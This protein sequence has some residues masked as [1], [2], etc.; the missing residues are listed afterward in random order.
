MTARV[1]VLTPPG[2]GAVATVAVAGPG[3]WD[4]IRSLFKPAVQSPLPD[5]PPLHRVWFGTL[6]GD[7]VVL[8]VRDVSPEPRVE[9][10]CHGGRRV[11]RWVVERFVECGCHDVGWESFAGRKP[12]DGRPWALSA[13]V[14]M[15]RAPTLRT[16]SILLDQHYGAF[17]RLVA[18][19]L[20]RLD[21]GDVA[22]AGA[23]LCNTSAFAPLG[24]RL[25][26]PWVVAVAGPPN[27]GK[28]SLLN[29][30]AGYQR[31]VV[32]DVPGTT[33]DVVTVPVAFDGWP[34]ELADTAGLREAAGL[35]AEGVER[36]RR[37]VADADLVV[38]VL[39]AA[40]P[41]PVWPPPGLSAERVLLVANKSDR[42]PAWA[43]D[44]LR[45]SAVTGHGVPELAAEVAR[46][47]VPLPPPPGAAVPF[48]PALAA[49][50]TDAAALVD[51]GRAGDAARLLRAA[52]D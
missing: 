23:I 34:V 45:V 8:A 39:D 2:A 7:Q 32:A 28:S 47:L 4:V 41:S 3:A 24:R 27:V 17:D 48:T 31:S 51:A 49:L 16:A 38:W 52:A 11:A 18:D 35:E 50:V 37:V 43:G 14:L 10:H 40:D 42:P 5:E 36:A 21:A 44:V 29:A 12:R 30:L 20:A 6:G 33:R 1:A 25:V 9:V 19:V 22:A 46:R 13:L 26:A 15:T